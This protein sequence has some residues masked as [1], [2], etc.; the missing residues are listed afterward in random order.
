MGRLCAR[1]Q[2]LAVAGNVWDFLDGDGAEAEAALEMGLNSLFDDEV[3]ISPP[4]NMDV[5]R[6]RW[7]CVRECTF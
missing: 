3:P 2:V 6:C 7:G 5:L 1:Y 4:P